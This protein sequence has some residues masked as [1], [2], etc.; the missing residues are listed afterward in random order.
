MI[1]KCFY[2]SLS[3]ELSKRGF[4]IAT[5]YA[6]E[7]CI[8]ICGINGNE[9]RYDYVRYLQKNYRLA[10]IKNIIFNVGQ[11]ECAGGFY[12]VLVGSRTKE[13]YPVI[14]I[15]LKYDERYYKM[16]Y[17]CDRVADYVYDNYGNDA[18]K[19]IIECIRF[20]TSKLMNVVQEWILEGKFPLHVFAEGSDEL[21]KSI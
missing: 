9:K 5:N 1:E 18:S 13:P 16:A 14:Y 3:D 7:D 8:G 11:N 17:A 4:F 6:P 21:I 15:T 19:D 10:A 12:E 2:Q 20:I